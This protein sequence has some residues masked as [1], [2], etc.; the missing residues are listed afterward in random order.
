M[1]DAPRAVDIQQGM[2][3]FIDHT[4]KEFVT[5]FGSAEATPTSIDANIRDWQTWFNA[6]QDIV[7]D[8]ERGMT[9]T[10]GPACTRQGPAPS[11]GLD[12]KQDTLETWFVCVFAQ[13]FAPGWADGHYPDRTA[14]LERN[15]ER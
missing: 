3:A 5:W 9:G 15:A 1:K 12:L 7:A 2:R 10:S 14:L 8:I 6:Q 13:R 4:R 11:P